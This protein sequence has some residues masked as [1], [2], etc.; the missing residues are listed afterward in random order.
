MVL[1]LEEDRYQIVIYFHISEPS[2]KGNKAFFTNLYTPQMFR[3]RLLV[4]YT[5]I[6]KYQKSRTKVLPCVL[7]HNLHV[8]LFH[9]HDEWFPQIFC[10]C[11][12]RLQDY[13][14]E[15]EYLLYFLDRHNGQLKLLRAK[16]STCFR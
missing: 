8:V 16:I 9:P 6:Y 5:V 7:L 3:P 11:Q 2:A 4:L 10:S 1:L 14:P 15:L 12:F 13:L